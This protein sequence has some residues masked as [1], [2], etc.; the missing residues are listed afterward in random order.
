MNLT[1]K[2]TISENSIYAIQ[3]VTNI[4]T[5]QIDGYSLFDKSERKELAPL[6]P[7]EKEAYEYSDELLE[8]RVVENES[9]CLIC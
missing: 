3:E 8:D 2:R 6:F 1:I 5:N 7:T 9:E 4:F